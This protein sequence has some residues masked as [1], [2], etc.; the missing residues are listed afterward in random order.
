MTHKIQVAQRNGAIKSMALL[1]VSYLAFAVASAS[2]LYAQSAPPAP[3]AGK[4]EAPASSPSAPAQ[5]PAPSAQPDAAPS[6]PAPADKQEA[7]ATKS[8]DAPLP[9]V[10]I[11]PPRPTPQRPVIQSRESTPAPV[12]VTERAKAKRTTHATRTG[13]VRATTPG[14][15][16]SANSVATA[17]AAAWPASQSQSG[18]TGQS[19][20]YQNSTSAATKI[21]TPIV[22][23]P[24][25]LS[26]VTKEFIA[27]NAFQNITDVTRYVPGVA[28][29]Q[30]EGNRDELIIRGVDSSANFF[31]NGFRDDVQIFRDFYNAQ[32]VE[33]LKGP[34][35]ITFGR[36]S[37]GGLL[38]R[39]LKEADGQ[40][41]YET[42]VQTGSWADQRYTLDAGQAVTEK[43]AA[44]LNMM[45]EKSDGFRQYFFLERYGINP[46]FTYKVDPM[47][48]FKFSYEFFHDNRTADR[49]N[50]SQAT[51]PTG[52]TKQNPGFP[53]SPNGD[54]Q[55]FYG[56]P[57]LNVAMA[58]VHTTQA[59][60]DHDFGNGLTVKNG[61]YYAEYDKFYQNVYP[62]GGT[63]SGAV[64]PTDTSFNRAAY[65]HTTN[66]QNF[67]NDTDFFY[68]LYTGP[69][70][71]SIAFGSEFGR[72][73]GIDVRNTGIFPNGTSTEADNPFSPGYFGPIS[74]I[75]QSAGSF[76]RGVTSP[77]SNSHYNLNIQSGYARDTIDITPWLQVIGA[78]R[79]DRFDEGATNLNDGSSQSLDNSFLSPQAAVILKPQANMS[80]WTAYMVSYLP[81]S[82]DQFSAITPGTAILKPQKFVNEEVGFKWNMGPRLLYT[83]SVYNLDRYNVPLNDPNNPGFFIVSG[84]NRTRGFESEL[85][86]YVT[87]EWQSWLGYA[88]TDARIVSA[89][90]AN[91]PAGN[92]I[93]LVP[94]NQFSWW[95]KY[96]FNPVWAA[97]L[98]VIYFSD[99]FASSDD[100]VV[101]PS[102]W[103][104]DA[105]LFAT[106]D[107][108]WKAQINVENLFNKGYWASADG[109]NNISPGQGRTIRGK[110]TANF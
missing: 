63:L 18:K 33:I 55:A 87:D 25:S 31:V 101:L 57:T 39:T 75:H 89:N 9:P 100:T 36:A 48:T 64:N 71:H 44:R 21:N 15:P 93:Q 47:T 28:V 58:N 94:L 56:S 65:N 40:R 50:P 90:G 97:S 66:R 104:F 46:T 92:R 74:F 82:G 110:L 80:L 1:S 17:I 45:Y 54:L 86:G 81:A 77:D 29:H 60:I 10:T 14:I 8:N 43:F 107:E 59:F 85:K 19:G 12:P 11:Y 20:V 88:Y 34:S 13:T 38:N 41:I 76:S 108:H 79:Y 22:N 49:G 96:Q 84:K 68:K 30:G 35:A 27:D 61:T 5:A 73:T 53:F 102:F 98:G 67:F 24:Q 6:S 95:N 7:P 4:T 70:Y 69:L 83:M 105:G 99:S 62:G 91:L 37:G 32:S 72:Q 51:L 3:E 16:V 106:I 52:S 78:G 26:V 23:I 2:T 103:R 109:N 42:T